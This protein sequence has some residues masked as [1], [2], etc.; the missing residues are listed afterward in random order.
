MAL[1]AC[2]RAPS[3]ATMTSTNRRMT[4]AAMLLAASVVA[5]R[6]LGF[7]RDA[8][9]AAQ[10]G[11][12]AETDAYHAAFMLPDLLNYLL[13]GGAL[14]IAFIPLFTRLS[15]EGREDDAWKLFSNVATVAV[16]LLAPAVAIAWWLTPAFVELMFGFGGDQ[17]TLTSDLTRI[18]LVGPLFFI[19]G[20]LLQATDLARKRFIAPALAP[21]VYNVCII[22]G[23]LALAPTMGAKGFSIGAIV[24]AFLGPFIVPLVTTRDILR[25][26]PH[27]DFRSPDLRRYAR[28]ALPL[29]FGASLLFFDEWIGRTI[30][31]RSDEGSITWLNNARRLMLVPVALVGQAIGQAALPFLADLAAR[32]RESELAETLGRT[33]RATLTLGI[34]AASA[35]AAAS[36]EIAR[37]VYERGAFTPGDTARTWPLLAIMGLAVAGWSAQI[38]VSRGYYARESTLRPMLISSTVVIASIPVY[39]VLERAF[40]LEGL[41][42][43]TVVGMSFGSAALIEGWRRTWGTSLWLDVR[44]GV[45]TGLLVALP[46]GTVAAGAAALARDWTAGSRLEGTRGAL[47][48]FAFTA[49]AWAVV[50]L[51]LLVRFGGPAGAAVQRRLAAVRRR[52]GR[53]ARTD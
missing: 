7:L 27:V 39:V 13:S 43:A 10:L 6:L 3:P 8:V 34:A 31:A 12:S 28:V 19:V 4:L 47:L 20:G 17:L 24:G 35:L 33:L 22:A 18:V 52:L 9:I 53:A 5:S 15:T 45:A 46:A 14:S 29:M 26:R 38:V 49:L 11:A 44:R 23:G 1:A 2:Q 50:G 48:V 25:F 16:A 32:G 51:P 42:A 37:I 40:G 30:A 21:L 36:P 41:A